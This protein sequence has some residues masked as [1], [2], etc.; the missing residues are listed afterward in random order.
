MTTNNASSLN[1]PLLVD[2]AA[3]PKL[4]CKPV[5]EGRVQWLRNLGPWKRCDLGTYGTGRGD[6][7]AQRQHLTRARALSCSS[8][9]PAPLGKRAQQ[10]R[11]RFPRRPRDV[12]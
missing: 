2:D 1:P 4:Q 3:D 11:E 9:G 8:R 5:H 10:C 7:C 12:V 6:C